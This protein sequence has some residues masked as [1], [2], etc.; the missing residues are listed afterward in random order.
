LPIAGL[1]CQM[2]C[3]G[4]P[5]TVGFPGPVSTGTTS[6]VSVSTTEPSAVNVAS[7]PMWM[8]TGFAIGPGVGVSVN[9]QDPANE[10]LVGLDW[11]SKGWIASI[12]REQKA[13]GSTLLR[14]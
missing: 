6:V 14:D 4:V 9:S 7:P 1:G 11:A 8:A 12:T 10:E 3:P 5:Y 13:Q 2:P